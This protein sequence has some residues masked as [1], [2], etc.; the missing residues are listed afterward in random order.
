MSKQAFHQ[1]LI[2]K[3]LHEDVANERRPE[4]SFFGHYGLVKTL[5][6]E[7]I[8]AWLD[9]GTVKLLV[10]DREGRTA[11]LHPSLFL[12]KDKETK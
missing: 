10:R 8:G 12:V 6:V 3:E 7:I 5:P 4:R 2:G 9:C 1:A 11:E